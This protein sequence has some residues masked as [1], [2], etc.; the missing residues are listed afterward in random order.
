MDTD[1]D[2]VLY[3]AM[4]V[5]FLRIAI[6]YDKIYDPKGEE[7]HKAALG[8]V[9]EAYS[10]AMEPHDLDSSTLNPGLALAC[11][12]MTILGLEVIKKISKDNPQPCMN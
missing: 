12:E 6:I 3:L 5:A 9:E 4:S 8:V 10:K 2:R 1:V 7:A 11:V